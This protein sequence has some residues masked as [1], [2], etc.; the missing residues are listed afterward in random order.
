MRAQTAAVPFEILAVNNNSPDDTLEVLSDLARRPG[1][2]LRFVT[3]SAQGIVP[4]RNRAIRESLDSDMLVFIDDDEIPL[5]GLLS[6]ASSAI[7]EVGAQCVGGRIRVHFESRPRPEWLDDELL[8]FLGNVDHGPEAFW[9]RDASTPVWS[10]LVAYDVRLFREDPTLRFDIRYNRAGNVVGGGSDGIMFRALLARNARLRYEPGMT[11][12]HD[13]EDWRLRR[14]YFLRLHFRGGRRYGRYELPDYPR[15][16]LGVPPFMLR[17][18][19]QQALRTAW[20]YGTGADGALRQA[21]NVAHTLG[22]M[23]GY[24]ERDRA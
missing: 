3:E 22:C 1:V 15:L 18:G 24:L 7:Q 9:I 8:A 13:V 19:L 4:A 10:G 12:L 11:V 20:M 23:R 2:P 16:L 6:A 21:M 14:S 17:Q 5:P